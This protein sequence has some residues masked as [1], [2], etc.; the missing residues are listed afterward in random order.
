MPAHLR[1]RQ[2]LLAKF[3]AKIIALLIALKKLIILGIAAA[4]AFLKR[5]FGGKKAAPGPAVSVA[6]PG[7]SVAAPP[8]AVDPASGVEQKPTE[9]HPGGQGGT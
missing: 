7:V 8:V 4:F 9:R 5:L 3:G 1:H 6:A 2:A